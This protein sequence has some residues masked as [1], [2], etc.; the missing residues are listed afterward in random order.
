MPILG[1]SSRG[2]QPTG[3]E[4]ME[5]VAK[6]FEVVSKNLNSESRV[7]AKAEYLAGNIDY[8]AYERF[9]KLELRLSHSGISDGELVELAAFINEAA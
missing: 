7:S 5:N 1:S 2:A 6:A 3:R 4:K 8:A 9:C